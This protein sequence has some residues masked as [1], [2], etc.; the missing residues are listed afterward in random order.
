MMN[1]VLRAPLLSLSGYGVHSRQVFKWLL[2]RKKNVQTQVVPWGIC[3]FLL[4]PE[5]EGGLIGE[6]MKR[7]IPGEAKADV[8]IQ[9]QLPDEWDPSIAACN[10]GVTAGIETDICSREWV[11]A[12]KRMDL[13]VV[14]SSFTK[15]TFVRSGVPEDKIVTIP[16]H[17]NITPEM[18]K[19]GRI[20]KEDIE[21]FPTD[22]NFLMFGQIT[23]MSADTD[24]K[25]T[26]FGLKWIAETFKNDPDVGVILKTNLG[27]HTAIDRRNSTELL[28]KVISEIK[29][30]PY[31]R[32]YLAHGMLEPTEITGIYNASNVKALVAP[33]RGEG[34]G[35]TI[36]DAAASGMPVLATGYSGHMD[37]MSRVK[38]VNIDYKL[39]QIPSSRVDNR[40]FIEGA[41][42]A[43]VDEK[44]FKRK[45]K[46]LR[47]SYDLPKKWAKEGAEK[48]KQGFS[49]EAVFAIYDQKIGH[50]V[51]LM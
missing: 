41:R 2:T 3:T 28:K 30:G 17:Y 24:R 40:I 43:D 33:T 39:A 21:G 22:F 20:L 46:K 9:V 25:N 42:W 50:L 7:S 12:C 36:I 49:E 19:L 8:S 15:Q 13:V 23:G 18:C 32:F 16:E 26:F 44:D 29:V 14:P 11:E 35:L 38:F 51:G 4:H 47:S 5:L 6:V 34:W 10:I 27:R 48:I 1:I 37:F 31:P 45:I